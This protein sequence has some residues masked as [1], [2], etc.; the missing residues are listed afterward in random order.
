MDAPEIWMEARRD[1]PKAL[2]TDTEGALGYL[3][4]TAVQPLTRGV[5]QVSLV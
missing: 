5:G 2:A 1:K 4:S 3:E